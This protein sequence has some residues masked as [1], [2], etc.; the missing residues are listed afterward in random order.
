MYKETVKF[1]HHQNLKVRLRPFVGAYGTLGLAFLNLKI[2]WGIKHH[3]LN[4]PERS[5]VTSSE[6]ILITF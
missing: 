6:I 4:L 2:E 1:L 3:L 5:F